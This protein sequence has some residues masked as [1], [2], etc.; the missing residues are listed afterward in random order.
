M[1]VLFLEK[2]RIGVLALFDA[3]MKFAKSEESLTPLHVDFFQLCLLAKTYSAA[4]QFLTCEFYDLDPSSSNLTPTD[5]LL[6]CYYGGRL[7][8]GLK[9][10]E[11]ALELFHLALVAP[12]LVT[13]AITLLVYKLYILV[14]LLEHGAMSEVPKFSSGPVVR[15]SRSLPVQPYLR[16]AEAYKEDQLNRVQ[17]IVT[18]FRDAFVE[19][20]CLGLVKQ[21]VSKLTRRDIKRLTKAYISLSLEDIASSIGSSSVEETEF[22]LLAMVEANEINVEINSATGMVKFSDDHCNYDDVSTSLEIDGMLQEV[23]YLGE[24]MNEVRDKI[25]LDPEYHARAIQSKQQ[26]KVDVNDLGDKM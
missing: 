15:F 23:I 9:R 20:N 13:N 21:I 16:L 10:Y 25:E 7:C 19:D 12:T 24:R 26:S 3:A 22:I 8:I 11:R 1:A 4:D 6:Y 18:E 2:P 5:Y 14:S 17:E